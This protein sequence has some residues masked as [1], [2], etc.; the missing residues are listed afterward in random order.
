MSRAIPMLGRIFGRLSVVATAPRNR[1][2]QI[3]W[4]CNCQCGTQGIVVN[5]VQLRDGKSQSCGCLST[6]RIARLNLRHGKASGGTIS[7]ELTAWYNMM[8]RCSDP[9]DK[10]YKRYGGRGIRVCSRWLNVDNFLVDMGPRPSVRHS[11]D[12]ID[13]NGDYEPSNCRWATPK[14]QQN[15]RT[16]NRRILWQGQEKTLS[17]WSFIRGIPTHTLAKRIDRWPID[18]AMT[19]PLRDDRRRHAKRI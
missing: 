14:V 5:G 9:A 11:V 13:P 1:F 6:E 3:Q 7:P 18:D 16:N 15:N 2:N 19:R 17:E 10:A 12:R 8:G 4:T